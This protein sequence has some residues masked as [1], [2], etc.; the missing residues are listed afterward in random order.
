MFFFYQNMAMEETAIWEQHTVTLH[1][2]SC[3]AVSGL[4]VTQS[5]AALENNR[6]KPDVRKPEKRGNVSIFLFKIRV[7][8]NS[9]LRSNE[10]DYLSM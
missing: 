7:A 1:R 2:V 5:T 9:V 4:C 6:G 3:A 10:L 8:I